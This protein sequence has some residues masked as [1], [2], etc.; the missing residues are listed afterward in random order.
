VKVLR[1]RQVCEKV[2]LSRTRIYAFLREGRF[3]KQV[4]LGPNTVGWFEHE[5][6][7]WLA[8]KSR[9]SSRGENLPESRAP[10]S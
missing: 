3:P 2:G 5:I 8:A 9:G 10:Q 7:Q 4:V 1:I 6:D